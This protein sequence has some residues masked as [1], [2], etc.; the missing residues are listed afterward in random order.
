MI[1]IPIWLFVI[2]VTLSSILTLIVGISIISFIR[3]CSVR[4]REIRKEIEEKYG[5]PSKER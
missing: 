3:Y 2:L 1:T 5:T 4:D